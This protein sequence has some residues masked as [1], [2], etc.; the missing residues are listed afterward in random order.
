MGRKL[1]NSG[2]GN[3][4]N[5]RSPEADPPPGNGCSGAGVRVVR[6]VRAGYGTSFSSRFGEPEPALV[7][8]PVVAPP[9]RAEATWAGVEEVWPAR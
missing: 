8:L 2:A 7:T 6:A 1:K 9:T 5:N 3:Y 4:G